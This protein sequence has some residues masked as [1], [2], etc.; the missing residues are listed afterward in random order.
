MTKPQLINAVDYREDRPNHL[1]ILAD[2]PLAAYP[3]ATIDV[4]ANAH[5]SRSFQ[6]A[7]RDYPCMSERHCEAIGGPCPCWHD[8]AGCP[9]RQTILARTI[10]LCDSGAFKRDALPL[11]YDR[12]FRLYARMEVAY[13]IMKD[14]LGDPRATLASAERALEAYGPYRDTFILVGVAQ[15]ISLEDY[16]QSYR[17]LSALGLTHV[18]VGGLL[19]KRPASARFAQVGGL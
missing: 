13:G 12:L 4:M 11:P 16:L 10:K 19:R 2:L 14:V 9:V 7:Y 3:R 6:D 17:D 15:G 18:A 8:R 1:Q 5:V